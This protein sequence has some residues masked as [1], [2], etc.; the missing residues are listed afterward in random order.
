QRREAEA[1]VRAARAVAELARV[2]LGRRK[3]LWSYGVISRSEF[4]VAERDYEVAAA[5]V[6][7]AQEH[8]ALVEDETRPEDLRRAAAEVE[9]A[10]STAEEARAL[11]EKAMVRAPIRGV[12]LRK[13]RHGGE[14]ISQLDTEPVVILGDCSRLRVRAE[15]DENDVAR[16][17]VNQ[18]AWV[19]ADAYGE[20]R[21]QAR[22]I[23][24]GNMLGRKSIRTDEPSE[25]NDVKI[26]E[27]L[28]ELEAGARVPVGMRVDVFIEP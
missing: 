23:R 7:S 12:I 3:Q 11:V 24:I 18:A 21:F 8:A 25:R 22:V 17:R 6:N 28:L 20:R 10:R 2:E 4:E 27:T 13:N 14:R 9:H 26:L 16:I 5:R 19:R 1:S 15:V